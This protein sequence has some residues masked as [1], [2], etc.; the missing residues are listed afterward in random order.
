MMHWLQ[1]CPKLILS[2]EAKIKFNISRAY[3]RAVKIVIDSINIFAG[4]LETYKWDDVQML[5]RET[6]ALKILFRCKG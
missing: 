5:P 3:W 6:R 4:R 2:K 1:A